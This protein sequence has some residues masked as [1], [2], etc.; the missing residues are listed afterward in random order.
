MPS[1]INR[2]RPNNN[3]V[4]VETRSLANVAALEGFYREETVEP[5][6]KE[7]VIK[8]SLLSSCES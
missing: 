2:E 6:T 8:F 4:I 7:M 1:E 5:G 3:R